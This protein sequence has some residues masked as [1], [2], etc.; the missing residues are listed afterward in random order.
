LTRFHV[1]RDA[2][3]LFELF[4]LE[5][6]LDC[7]TMEI[8]LVATVRENKSVAVLSEYPVHDAKMGRC[9]CL[10]SAEVS[11]FVPKPMDFSLERIES[12]VKRELQI[13]AGANR[14]DLVAAS[15]AGDPHLLP[16]VA[17]VAR[18]TAGEPDIDQ[19]PMTFC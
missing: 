3:A 14:D 1:E 12:L 8:H 7:V 15:L 6:F 13:G 16:S 17:V 9:R 10:S 5:P 19:I 4:E 18:P 11:L 2:I